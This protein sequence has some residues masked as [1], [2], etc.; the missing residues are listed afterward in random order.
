MKLASCNGGRDR[1]E[2][3]RAAQREDAARP[4]HGGVRDLSRVSSFGLVSGF[5]FRVSGLGFGVWGLS[6]GF[7]V[8]GL[9]FGVRGLGFGVR[10]VGFGV[11]GVGFGVRGLGSRGR[12]WLLRPEVALP[13]RALGRRL[14]TCLSL[15]ATRTGELQ[16]GRPGGQAVRFRVQCRVYRS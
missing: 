8:C 12:A 2:R 5:E 1:G 6:L 9:G 3:Q 15:S 4:H 7:G 10:G 14:A 16:G 11:R 13:P